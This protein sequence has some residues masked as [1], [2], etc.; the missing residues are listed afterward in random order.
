MQKDFKRLI[1]DLRDISKIN[2]NALA[3]NKEQFNLNKVISSIVD[4]IRE[5]IIPNT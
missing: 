3:L 5:H 4:D 1:S 2:N